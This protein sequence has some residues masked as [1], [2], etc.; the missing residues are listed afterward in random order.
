MFQ[1]F[2][3][4]KRRNRNIYTFF[5]FSY[6]FVFYIRNIFVYIQLSISIEENK[7]LMNQNNKRYKNKLQKD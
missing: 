6:W 3:I 7:D 1:K 4:T 5:L 2:Y